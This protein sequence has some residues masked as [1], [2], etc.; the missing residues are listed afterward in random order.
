[1]TKHWTFIGRTGI[2]GHKFFRE[3]ETGRIAVADNSG[4]YPHQTEDGVLYLDETRKIGFTECS[5][6][7]PLVTPDGRAT[8]TPI[9]R[10]NL[11]WIIRRWPDLWPGVEEVTR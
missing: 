7:L 3:T 10:S 2:G 9:G 4:H 5:Y 1:M 6:I 11:T 8:H